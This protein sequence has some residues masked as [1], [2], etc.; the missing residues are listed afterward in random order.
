MLTRADPVSLDGIRNRHTSED[1]TSTYAANDS[2]IG[3]ILARNIE[4][5]QHGRIAWVHCTDLQ[6]HSVILQHRHRS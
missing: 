5:H 6:F 4:G 1:Q 3:L 2:R